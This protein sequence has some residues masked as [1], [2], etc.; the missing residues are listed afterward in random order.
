MTVFYLGLGILSTLHGF[1][2]DPYAQKHSA[3]FLVSPVTGAFSI[4]YSGDFVKLIRSFDFQ[5]AVNLNNPYYQN[6]FGI[7]NGTEITSD[8]SDFNWVRMKYYVISPMM[9]K[10]FVNQIHTLRLGPLYEAYEVED[11]NEDEVEDGHVTN[12][13][14]IGLPEDVFR[15][16]HYVGVLFNYELNAIENQVRPRSGIKSSLIVKYVNEPDVRENGLVKVRGSVSFYVTLDVRPLEFTLASRVGAEYITGNYQFYHTPG[17]G[18]NSN[19]RGYRNE[20]FRG[21]TIFYQNIDLRITLGYW[22]N[23]IL[24]A[25]FGLIGGFD[26]GRVWSDNDADDD[27]HLGYSAGIWISP[28]RFLVITPYAA[29]SK[30]ETQFNLRVG[31]F[32]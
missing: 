4:F 29:F 5:L 20:R 9:K 1:R 24:P 21:E 31:F 22:D 26:Y 17:L 32:F 16:K 18:T 10:T 25:E 11:E 19:L 30:E 13:P 6:Y 7:G 23:V 8:E 28:L 2:R 3:S 27:F 15:F 12:D 14:S